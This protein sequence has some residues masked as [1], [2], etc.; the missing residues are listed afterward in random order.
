MK[1]SA[2]FDDDTVVC[3]KCGKDGWI[4]QFKFKKEY[5]L[6]CAVHTDEMLNK[7]NDMLEEWIK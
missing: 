6:F 3:M 7:I 5:W 1:E 4:T 2:K